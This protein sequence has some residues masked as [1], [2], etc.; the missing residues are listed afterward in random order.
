MINNMIN[1]FNKAIYLI[2]N[3]I[4]IAFLFIAMYNNIDKTVLYTCALFKKDFTLNLAGLLFCYSLIGYIAGYFACM[5]V[6]SRTESL[7]NAYQKRHENISIEKDENIAK[8]ASLEAKIQTLEVALE[9]A[10]KNK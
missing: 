8:I 5:F 2:I 3:L 6:K 4:F 9:S 1:N 7:C 10:L